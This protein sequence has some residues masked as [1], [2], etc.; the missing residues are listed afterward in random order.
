MCRTHLRMFKVKV[1]VRVTVLHA[2]FSARHGDDL[3]TWIRSASAVSFGS[4]CPIPMAKGTRRSRA[5][6]FIIFEFCF[7]QSEQSPAVQ[8]KAKTRTHTYAHIRMHTQTHTHTHTHT[9]LKKKSGYQ[10]LVCVQYCYGY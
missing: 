7:E 6:A 2:P 1:R 8:K 5:T 3:A 4:Y 10:C 9:Q